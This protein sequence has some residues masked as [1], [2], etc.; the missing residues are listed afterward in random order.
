MEV[1]QQEPATGLFNPDNEVLELPSQRVSA[2]V[3]TDLA[4]KRKKYRLDLK[5]RFV[6]VSTWMKNGDNKKPK[7]DIVWQQALASRKGKIFS[8]YY[9]LENY[10]WGPGEL[11]NPSHAFLQ[12]IA[13]DR[14][15]IFESEP[16]HQA[17]VNVSLGDYWSLIML[18]LPEFDILKRKGSGKGGLI[19]GEYRAESGSWWLGLIGA[20]HDHERPQFGA[21]GQLEIFSGTYIYADGLRGYD[22]M[23]KERSLAQQGSEL[24]GLR[25]NFE[26]GN[27]LRLEY[28]KLD[29]GRTKDEWDQLRQG[30]EL[31]DVATRVAILKTVAVTEAPLPSQEY[32]YSSLRMPRLLSPDSQI[33]LF[34]LHSLEDPSSL[35]GLRI[36]DT[37]G[38][39]VEIMGQYVRAVGP[40]DRDMTRGLK[41]TAVVGLKATY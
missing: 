9:G 35:I 14:L 40:N 13:L 33:Q 32:A 36:E 15:G 11:A 29:H 26:N 1:R 27:D 39:H 17:R 16:Q 2:V 38:D 41:G 10:Q 18:Y 12:E 5:P 28:Y 30:L 7:P 22:P 4:F 23:A 31:F 3:R 24:A 37:I 20:G 25:Y 8:L 21:Y 6:A 19:K 34:V